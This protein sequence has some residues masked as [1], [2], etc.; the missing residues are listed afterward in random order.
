LPIMTF[1]YNLCSVVA[2]CERFYFSHTFIC[3]I[4]LASFCAFWWLNSHRLCFVG[5]SESSYKGPLFCFYPQ[6]RFYCRKWSFCNF[7]IL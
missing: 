3:K 2:K 1:S 4:R 5:R 6:L 7:M